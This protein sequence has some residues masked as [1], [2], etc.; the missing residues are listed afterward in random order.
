MGHAAIKDKVKNNIT[1]NYLIYKYM[2]TIESML[3]E[4]PKFSITLVIYTK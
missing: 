1:N 2:T 3:Y 4:I